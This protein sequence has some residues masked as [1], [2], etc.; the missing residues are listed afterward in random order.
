MRYYISLIFAFWFD[1]TSIC[2]GQYTILHYFNG[3]EGSTPV[4]N[5]VR[6][7]N[8]LFGITRNGGTYGDGTIFSM[9]TSGNAFRKLHDFDSIHGCHPYGSIILNGKILYGMT[10][11]GGKANHG[12]IFS[13]D[14]T[15]SS[16]KILLYFNDT[17]GANPWGSLIYLNNKLYGMVYSGGPYHGGCI[18][19]IDTDGSAFKDIYDFSIPNG[20]YPTGTLINS[21]KYFYGMTQEDGMYGNVFSVDTNGN[22]YKDLHDFQ[23]ISNDGVDPYGDVTIFGGKLFGMTSEGGIPNRGVVF[24]IDTDGSHYRILVQL[25]STRIINGSTPYSDLTLLNKRLYGM[26]FTGGWYTGGDI[27]SIDTN[28]FNFRDLHDFDSS[29][30]APWGSLTASGNLF[31]GTATVGGANNNGVIFKIDTN[32]NITGIDYAKAGLQALTVYPNPASHQIT[33]QMNA[34]QNQ[35]IEFEMYNMLG[36]RVYDQ[37]LTDQNGMIYQQIDV[38]SLSDGIYLLKVNEGNTFY[39]QKVIKF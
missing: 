28:G 13:M 25:F 20:A 21:D 17:N 8:L 15:G 30:A 37:S 23:E 16:F 9:D 7:N 29:G 24:S 26:T 1:A 12:I 18:F 4:G 19:S 32:A 34:G 38:S 11:Y 2:Q 10:I 27:F 39:T 31:Y 6:S 36:Q 33:V 3:V 14:T 5:L 22:N 35:N